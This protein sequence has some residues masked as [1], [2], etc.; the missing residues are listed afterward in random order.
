MLN[1][2]KGIKI[3]NMYPTSQDI[4]INDLDDKESSYCNIK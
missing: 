1:K 2:N 3:Y 4:N